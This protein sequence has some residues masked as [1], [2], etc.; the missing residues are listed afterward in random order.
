MLQ[1]RPAAAIR[2]RTIFSG[3]QPTGIPHL[4]N[5]LGALQQWA[6]IQNE[7]ALDA[8]LLFCIVD[9]HA[10]TVPQDPVALRESR[11]Q[12]LASLMAVGL[13]PQ[14]S[15]LF[16]QSSVP[17]HA[18]LMWILSCQASVGYLSRMTQWKSKIGVADSAS[19]SDPASRKKLKLGL[20]SYPVLQTADIVLYGATHVPVGADQ[21]QHIEF[22]RECANSFN[23]VYG[24]V[25][26]LPQTI[27]SP[28][29]RVMSLAKPSAKMS[30]SDP[31]PKSRILISDSPE[32]ISAK[33]RAALTDSVPG[34]V[35][36]DTAARPGVSNLLEILWH[37]SPEGTY[38]GIEDVVKD[39]QG[40]SLRAFKEKVAGVA[41]VHLRP[42]R[43]SYEEAYKKEE[44]RALDEVEKNGAERARAV[45]AKT[46]VDVKQ[47]MGLA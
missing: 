42:I 24:P 28:A 2:R 26:A 16:Y 44:G 47:A 15:I 6:K 10:I 29:K 37:L 25:L 39:C 12:M 11:R 45:A 41:E 36:Y 13:D 4:G 7:S 33:L 5:Y 40:L 9:L 46:M 35:S 32:T 22:A 31:D 30:K 27:L 18:E 3:I 34:D 1:P 19:L 38:E 8:T 17:A 23:H 21:A 43:K 20:F 14:R